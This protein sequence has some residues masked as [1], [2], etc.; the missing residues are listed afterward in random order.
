MDQARMGKQEELPGIVRSWNGYV[1]L[2]SVVRIVQSTKPLTKIPK[3]LT[4]EPG[5]SK[6]WRRRRR[7]EELQR[8]VNS[9]K[10]VA[11]V[12]RIAMKMGCCTLERHGGT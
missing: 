11:P 4:R 10:R 1:T 2:M 8:N 3:V 6:L 12:D 9:I 7:P 5:S